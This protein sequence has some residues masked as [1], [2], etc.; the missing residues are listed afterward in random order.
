M[1]DIKDIIGIKGKVVMRTVEGTIH[2]KNKV[3]FRARAETVHLEH[4]DDVSYY[5]DGKMHYLTGCDM[6][7]MC[8]GMFIGDSNIIRCGTCKRR[9]GKIIRSR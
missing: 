4:G 3:L 8:H 9:Q 1:T 6:C 2:I 7:A 5:K